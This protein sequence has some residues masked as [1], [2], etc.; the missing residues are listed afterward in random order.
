MVLCGKVTDSYSQF[1]GLFFVLG[2]MVMGI[3]VEG[4]VLL[5]V[6]LVLLTIEVEGGCSD[7]GGGCNSCC[8]FGDDDGEGYHQKGL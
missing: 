8:C 5:A 4:V 3:V 2:V 6:V 7:G 1:A